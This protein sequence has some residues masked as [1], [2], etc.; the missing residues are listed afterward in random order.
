MVEKVGEE[1]TGWLVDGETDT[2]VDK[3]GGDRGV[4]GGGTAV[5]AAMEMRLMFGV[6]HDALMIRTVATEAMEQAEL[7]D[8]L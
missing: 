4:P 3:P 6:G 7:D 2:T 1:E 8:Q 5:R